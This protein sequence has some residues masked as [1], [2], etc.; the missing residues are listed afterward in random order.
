LF[1]KINKKRMEEFL[2]KFSDFHDRYYKSETGVDAANYLMVEL[3]EA[4]RES[5]LNVSVELFKNKWPQPSVIARVEG[6]RQGFPGAEETVV[7]G[8]HL[9]SI[10]IFRQGGRAPG[11]DDDGSGTTT[12]LETFRILMDSPEFQPERSIE[13]HFY[14][15]EELGLWGSQ[16]VAWRYVQKD[17]RSIYA[18]IQNDCT[19]YVKPSQRDTPHFGLARDF[20]DDQLTTYVKYLMGNYSEMP[21]VE[22]KCGYGCSDHA[23]W[24]KV[25]VRSSF[26]MEGAM[27]ELSPFLHSEND[28]ISK[29]DF[30]HI[31]EFVR[32]DLAAAFELSKVE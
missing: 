14:S 25:G 26:M 22:T 31:A 32:V 1:N 12:V 19:G 24:K 6:S 16:E 8:A 27:N 5:N 4:A 10:N 23:S 11:A 21:V 28:D 7:I 30:D 29:V 15:A 3:Q 2:T 18:M 9:D 17:S 13:F 20:S